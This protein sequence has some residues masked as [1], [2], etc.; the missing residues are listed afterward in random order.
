[1]D[2]I[3]K[4]V[5]IVIVLIVALSIAFFLMKPSGQSAPIT[6]SQAV[7]TVLNDIKESNPG[8]NVTVLSV[9]N[10]TIENN[11][12]NITLS[13]VYNATRPCPT[14]FI[15]R[16]NYPATGLIPYNTNVWTQGQ[17]IISNL[18]NNPPTYV[19]SSP[20]IAIA[21]SYNQ[22]IK[23]NI[24]QITY[25]VSKYGYNNTVVTAKLYP[26]LYSNYTG[27]SE[28]FSNVWLVKYS[29]LGENYSAYAVI[30]PS[31]SVIANYTK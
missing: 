17:C 28:N 14:L 15:E 16:F 25:F 1:M 31:G 22:S 26:E 24:T 9:S 3:A 19:I 4:V 20:Y 13:I 5:V 29:T 6:A 11:S 30:G 8:A 27:L 18:N 10:S 12:Y 23:Y 21:R 2:L 7:Q